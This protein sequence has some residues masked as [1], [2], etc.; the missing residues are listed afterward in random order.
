MKRIVLS[1]ALLIVMLSALS[2]TTEETIKLE[3]TDDVCTQM[4]DIEFMKYCYAE[5][6]ANKDGKVSIH[7]AASAK[8]MYIEGRYI[9]SLKGIE[10]FINLLDLVCSDNLLRS[11]DVSNCVNLIMLDCV[12][13][14]L[15]TLDVS[16]CTNLRTIFCEY[17]HLESLDVST[18]SG[19]TFVNCSYN[20]I[21][22]LYLSSK[23][24]PELQYWV[25]DYTQIVY[26]D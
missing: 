10:Y 7:E 12:D 13:N 20:P 2:C 9:T 19:L 4:D 17:N 16:H 14:D 6:D 5:Y 1:Q 15:E 3:D 11:L 23:N 18:C 26:L 21:E 25:Q 24:N 8:F 22:T